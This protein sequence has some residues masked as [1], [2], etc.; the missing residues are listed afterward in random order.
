[1]PARKTI[2]L[3]KRNFAAKGA[4]NQKAGVMKDKRAGRGGAKNVMT[5]ALRKADE[6]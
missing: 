5:E 2:S 6:L 1:M 4:K 3:P